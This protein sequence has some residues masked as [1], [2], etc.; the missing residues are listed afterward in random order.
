MNL[1]HPDDCP[2][3]GGRGEIEAGLTGGFVVTGYA[4]S[5]RTGERQ[6]LGH[7]TWVRPNPAAVDPHGHIW[8]TRPNPVLPLWGLAICQGCHGTGM[9]VV[10]GKDA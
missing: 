5:T 3:C 4:V 6:A 8:F 7:P 9:K 2:T 1:C 10:T